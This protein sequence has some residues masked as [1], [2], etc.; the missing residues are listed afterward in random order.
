[1]VDRS[2]EFQQDSAKTPCAAASF[3][4]RTS[5][6]DTAA[7][8]GNRITTWLTFPA[9]R[10]PPPA[11]GPAL[12]GKAKTERDPYHE[13]LV[14]IQRE[15]DKDTKRLKE[16]VEELRTLGVEPKSGSEGLVDFP[17]IWTAARFV[18]AGSWVNHR[19]SSGMTGR[20]LRRPAT[21]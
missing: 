5:Q 7:S 16:Y 9:N 13:E 15:M 11:I 12:A 20:R 6:C 1:M 8:G 3:H 4:A 21:P 10:E 2:D 19:S 14:Q 18:C 17:A